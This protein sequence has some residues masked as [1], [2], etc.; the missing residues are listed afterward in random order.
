MED[1]NVVIALC[2]GCG[3][4]AQDEIGWLKAHLAFRCGCGWALENDPVELVRA[5]NAKS[6]DQVLTVK[7]QRSKFEY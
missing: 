1:S 7:M 3:N 2:P 4:P 5:L 6:S